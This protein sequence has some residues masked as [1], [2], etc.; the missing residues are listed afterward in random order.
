M[1]TKPIHK[2]K[3]KDS[4]FSVL[5]ECQ[6]DNKSI[7]KAKWLHLSRNFRDMQDSIYQD[8]K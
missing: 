7:L 5:L 3:N 8:E 1:H 6:M 4:T 2:F